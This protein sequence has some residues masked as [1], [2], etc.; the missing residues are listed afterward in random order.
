[1]TVAKKDLQ[2]KYPWTFPGA[3]ASP[4]PQ[5]GSGSLVCLPV[6]L[7]SPE[8]SREDPETDEEAGL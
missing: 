2:V 1:M 4:A 6:L 5:C 7:W 3:E 8:A